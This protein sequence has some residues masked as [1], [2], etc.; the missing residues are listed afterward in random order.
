MSEDEQRA[1]QVYKDQQF[2]TP[3]LNSK[4]VQMQDLVPSHQSNLTKTMVT[5]ARL[6][7]GLFLNLDRKYGTVD[8][9]I[10]I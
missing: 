7:F 10:G 4:K 8:P 1:K 3:G 5:S 6:P 9:C 2:Q